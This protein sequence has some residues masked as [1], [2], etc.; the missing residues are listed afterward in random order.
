MSDHRFAGSDDGVDEH[1]VYDLSDWTVEQRARLE[2]VLSG[3]GLSWWWDAAGAG[4]PAGQLVVAETCAD[5]VEELIEEIDH[6]DALEVDDSAD[7]GGAEILSQL[8]LASDV[9]IAAPTNEV[10]A[11][12]AQRAA[13][14]AAT[15]A[16]PYGLDD[17]T[18]TE[19]RRRSATLAEALASGLEASVV[20][21]ARALRQAVRPLV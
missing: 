7:D 8:Y 12:E 10:A 18:W 21:A 9:L 15:I 5:V 19:V 11:V 13:Q 6:P 1:V 16:A 14:Q 4:V 17:H 20:G 3:E 2:G